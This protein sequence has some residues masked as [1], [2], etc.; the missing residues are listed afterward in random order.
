MTTA[1][2]FPGAEGSLTKAFLPTADFN[3]ETPEYKNRC[4]TTGD[5]EGHHKIRP[6]RRQQREARQHQTRDITS[7]EEVDTRVNQ[8]IL[9]SLT[10][11][12]SFHQPQ[13]AGFR[14]GG[15]PEGLYVKTSAAASTE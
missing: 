4:C 6:Q 12:T 14:V 9:D 8:F 10:D 5:A 2:S 1:S 3:V 11:K 13:H 7:V 15:T